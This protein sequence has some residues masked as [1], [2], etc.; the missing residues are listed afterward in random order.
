MVS[1]IEITVIRAT[2]ERC[3]DLSRSIDL[4]TAS[5]ARTGEKAIAGVTSGLIGPGEEVTWCARHL[6]IS[7]RLTSRITAFDRPV[8]FQDTMVRGGAFRFFQHD[9]YFQKQDGATEMK[10]V[11]RFAAPPPVLGR[12]AELMLGPYLRRFL[13]ERNAMIKRV[14]EG[15]EWER[16]LPAP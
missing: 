6:G 11:L 13:K 9:H 4:H 16:Y 15:D 8:Y 12:V 3:F 5:T 1:L 7:Q 2:I 10:D 14:A